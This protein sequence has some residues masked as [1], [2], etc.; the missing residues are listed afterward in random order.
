MKAISCGVIIIDKT[1]RQLL[2]CHP[3]L[4]SYKDG[5][6]DIPKGHL[7]ANETHIQAALRELE[8]E[9]GIKLK[10]EDLF[11]CGMFLYTKYKDLHLYV[12]EY[13]V[14]LPEL[15]CSTYFHFE[16]RQPLEVDSY[17]LVSDD[18][19]QVY[20]HSLAPLV[21]QCIERYKTEVINK[22]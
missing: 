15:K 10:E 18:H 13:D 3:S 5:N 20:Y 22:A 4:H 2:A 8:E 1:T 16:G 14:F 12:A 7:E 19:T 11:D 21:K 9:A 17:K 6:W